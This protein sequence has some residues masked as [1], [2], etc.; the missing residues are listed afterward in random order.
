LSPFSF[1]QACGSDSYLKACLNK[2]TQGSMSTS[3]CYANYFY[4]SRQ[5]QQLLVKSINAAL[6]KKQPEGTDYKQAKKYLDI[7]QLIN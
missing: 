2:G 7:S 5:N 4:K 6:S 3:L 1:V